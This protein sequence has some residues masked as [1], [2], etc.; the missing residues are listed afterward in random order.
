M[1]SGRSLDRFITSLFFI[2]KQSS[3]SQ[4]CHKCA[5]LYKQQRNSFHTSTDYYYYYYTQR[6]TLAK[7]ILNANNNKYGYLRMYSSSSS[8]SLISS[9][10]FISPLQH[11]DQE[12][13]QSSAF[14]D[15][16]SSTIAT[17]YNQSIPLTKDE[18]NSNKKD[19]KERRDASTSIA[20][21]YYAK[22][23]NADLCLQYYLKYLQAH[24]KLPSQEALHQLIRVLY[25]KNHLSGLFTFHDTLIAYY[26]LHPP[27][28]RQVN[29]LGY[30]YTM[31]INCL[32]RANHQYYTKVHNNMNNKNNN[33][34]KKKL[35][36]NH[37]SSTSKLSSLLK[38]KATI[39]KI[40]IKLCQEM[41]QFK[42]TKTTVLYNTLIH[43]RVQQNDPELAYAIYQELKSHCTP[44]NYTYTTLLHLTRQ[45]KDYHQMLQLLKEMERVEITPDRSMVSVISLTLCDQHDYTNAKLFLDELC[46]YAPHLLGANY[47]SILLKSLYNHYHQYHHQQQEEKQQNQQS[48]LQQPPHQ[49]NSVK[50]TS[51]QKRRKYIISVKKKNQKK[52]KK[53]ELRRQLVSNDLDNSNNYSNNKIE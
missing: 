10:S 42:I 33:E 18:E 51:K 39:F 2:S 11:Q 21:I 48:Q 17:A 29:Q 36:K 14:I 19:K 43:W 30:M 34:N 52:R 9:Q 46:Y 31:L 22:Q 6:N 47:K 26:K 49:L 44:T 12:Q 16:T 4:K 50:L 38:D 7:Y 8:S 20:M 25:L 13:M 45:Q 41:Q 23:G 15:M 28:R 1:L 37:H 53:L 35:K 32:I 24:G 27:S 3:Y 5:N 40:I